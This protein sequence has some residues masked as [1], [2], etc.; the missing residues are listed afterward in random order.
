MLRDDHPA[1]FRISF[2]LDGIGGRMAHGWGSLL[3]ADARATSPELLMMVLVG[4]RQRTLAEFRAL[5]AGLS[6]EASGTQLSGR[7]V[8]ECYPV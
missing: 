5:N 1:H 6:V 4:G 7:V 2:D 8:V 3:D